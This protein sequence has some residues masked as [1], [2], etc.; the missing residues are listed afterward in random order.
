MAISGA[1]LEAA[2]ALQD[3]PYKISWHEFPAAAPL[4]EAL[5]A[6]AIDAGVVGDAPFTFG[7]AAGVR[8]RVIAAR[9]STQKGLACSFAATVRARVLDD[10]RGKRIAT[11]RGSIG[12]F[13]FC[14]RCAGKVG[15]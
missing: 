13:W 7:F 14:W 15:R 8:M 5:N 6:E 3:V 2:N 12:H 1:L 10:L 4:I 9:R 11:G